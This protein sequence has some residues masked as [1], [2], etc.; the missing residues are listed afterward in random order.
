MHQSVFVSFDC[1][2]DRALKTALISQAGNL[3]AP[4]K[5]EYSSVRR[6]GS[7][8]RAETLARIE[9]SDQLIV[10]C[11]AN[12]DTAPGVNEELAMARA[13]GIPYFL[14]AGGPGASKPSAAAW[15]DRVYKWT[16]DNLKSLVEGRR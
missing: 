3:D 6:E 2:R 9:R 14:L 16:W 13:T 11:G 15:T 8:W 4:F 10:V 12:T 5:I 7:G 1:D